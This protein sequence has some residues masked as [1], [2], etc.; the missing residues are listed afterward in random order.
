M[1]VELDGPP[2]LGMN[3]AVGILTCCCPWMMEPK[4]FENLTLPRRLGLI[5]LYI[6]TTL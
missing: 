1:A 6:K 5:E 2:L 4:I 3:A